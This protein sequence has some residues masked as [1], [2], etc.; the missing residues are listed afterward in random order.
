MELTVAGQT[1]FHGESTGSFL[2]MEGQKTP[3]EMGKWA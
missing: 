3:L 1:T 2:W